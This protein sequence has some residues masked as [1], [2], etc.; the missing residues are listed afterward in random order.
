MR[1]ALRWT[2]IGLA[3]TLGV[4]AV[5]LAV[6]V[7]GTATPPGRAAIERLVPT[8]TTNEVRIGGLSGWIFGAAH[9]AHIDVRDAN[10]VWLTIDGATLDWSPLQ[11]LSG[12]VSV[13]RLTADQITVARRPLP[14]G[15]S[16]GKT[17]LPLRIDVA[18]LAVGR[19]ILAPQ[20]AGK[21]ATLALS[22]AAHLDAI[23]QGNVHIEIHRVDGAGT[24]TLDGALEPAGLHATLHM[25]EPADGLLASLAGVPA[26]GAITADAT[27]TGSLDAIA[28]TANLTGGAL[29]AAITGRVDL[30]HQAADLTVSATAPAMT[31]RPDLSWHDI[32]LQGQVHGPLTHPAARA[33]LT[34]NALTAGN[35]RVDQVSADLSGDEGSLSLDGALTGVHLPGAQPNVLA[36]A[37]IQLHAAAQL[38]APD[39]PVNFTITHTLFAVT[40]HATLS[41][42]QHAELQLNVPDIAPLATAGGIANVAGQ[43][44]LALQ[45]TRNGDDTNLAA[46][47]SVGLT[48]APGPTTSV[49]GPQTHLDAR[50][51]LHDQ[52]ITLSRLNI[53][54]GALTA[55]AQGTLAPGNMDLHWT[56]A[57][58]DLARVQPTVNGPL[59]VTGAVQGA[60]DNL[61]VSA[62]I[63]GELSAPGIPAGQLS[64]HV[65]LSNLPNAPHGT[66]TATGSLLGAPLTLNVAATR[67][68]NMTTIAIDQAAWKSA[69]AQGQVQVPL[70][71]FA[72]QGH[73][74][75]AMDHLDDLTPLLGRT[76]RG[77]VKGTLD[78]TEQSAHLTITA[79]DAGLPGAAT[80]AKAALDATVHDP[81]TSPSFDARLTV[82]GLT[83]GTLHGAAQLTA[84]G[85]PSA[86]AVRLT[87]TAPN[88]AGAAANLTAAATVDANQRA[89]TIAS[90]QAAWKQQTL[91]LLA[92]AR[93]D[94]AAGVSVQRVR[95]GLQQ[96]VLE[97]NGRISPTLDL[98]LRLQNLPAHL[99][100]AIDP[101][102]AADGTIAADARLTGAMAQPNG[103]LRLTVRGLRATTGPGR[104]L[105][106]T[107]LTATVAL[108]GTTA[109]LDANATA[110]PSHLVLT[111]TVGLATP[112]ALDLR[113]TGAVDLAM[114]DPLLT[115]SGRR[116]RGHLALDA[117]IMGNVATPSVTGTANLTDGAFR[118]FAQGIDLSDISTAV[119]A[120]GGAVRLTQL[121]AKA[122][123]GTIN[124]N[125]SVDLTT[126]GM[127]IDLTVTARQARP[128]ANDLLT[129]SLDAD[130]TVRGNLA[131][132]LTATGHVMVRRADIRIPERLPATVATLNMRV[133]GT[134]PPPP[135]PPPAQV[136]L[137]LT[138]D[139]PQQIFVR[140]RGVD[141]ELGGKV[142]VI[143][144]TAQPVPSG[145]FTLRHGQV[146]IAGQVLSFTSGQVS[147]NGGSLTDPSLNFVASTTTSNVTANL[148]ITGTADA[149]KITLSSTPPL[150]QDEVLSYLLYGTRTAA[151]GPLEIA[152][153]AAT[154]ASLSGAASSMSNPLENVRQALGLDRLSVGSGSQL[155]AGRYVAR[156]VY[157]GARQSVTGTGTQAVVQVDLA[158]GLKLEATAGTATTTSAT[159]AGGSA[160]A[161][162]VGIRYQFEY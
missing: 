126:P 70:D 7:G 158:K 42:T 44:A 159:G 156:D 8:V 150:P 143:G 142:V 68:G 118:D 149:P 160:D 75:F 81:A 113:A 54:S 124:A 97:A 101:S 91:R 138:I 137:N 103:T 5:L 35:A 116:A 74:T 77:S 49:L 48:S 3:G 154:L 110:G 96:A 64:A 93:I 115:P 153:I 40:G 31:P 23:D 120:D 157:V 69:H 83:A 37:P 117:T 45:A 152:Q 24:Y 136:A 65:A 20:V 121:A 130:L 36:T 114:T 106:P 161:A 60:P 84:Q 94:L 144:T 104:S 102:L 66:L 109:R 27:L 43:L 88:L 107:D 100:T 62:D 32:A 10:G 15:S 99:A 16:S 128:L 151:L 56:I 19:L 67:S 33:T 9:I 14:S 127:P 73:L 58:A 139:A 119:T 125:G 13:R 123:P 38:N 71:T 47:G 111:G 39:R 148:T 46:T 122:G 95:L 105:P 92:P 22:G 82:A 108:Q 63:T 12:T 140:G 134:P 4:I 52:T 80:V 89:L 26:V 34:I 57:V 29:H 78:G 6:L 11:L 98:T 41:G 72:P 21:A 61:A 76:L 90:L 53:D 79:S 162:S 85:S 25:A 146:S 59:R 30:T 132:P 129:A 145:G 51:T 28:T 18:T 155:E 1:R 147:F 135:A 112:T 141:A 50:A 86:L 87:A 133:A 17:T 131:G 2:G 55:G